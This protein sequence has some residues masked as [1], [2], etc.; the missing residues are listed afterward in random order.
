MVYRGKPSGACERCRSRRLKCDQGIPSCS[1]CIRARVDCPGYR[2]RLDLGFRDQNDEVISRAQRSAQK[3][4]SAA[5]TPV[6]VEES[7]SGTLSFSPRNNVEF[8]VQDL[9]KGY[10]FSHYITGGLEGGHMSYLLPLIADPGNVAVNS[11]LNAVGL[12]ALS[13]I[14]LSPQMMLKAR[15]EYTNALSETN[16]ALANT[17]MSKRDDT[18]AAVVLLGMFEVLTC[19]DGS[20]IDRWMKHMEGATKLIEFRGVDQLSRQEGLNLFTQLR[21]QIH[22]GK[23]YQEKYSSP[24]LFQLSENA[25]RYRDSND[26]IVDELGLEVIRLS[27]FCASMKDGSVTDPG[28]IIRTALTIDANLTSLFISVPAAWSYRTVKVPIFNGEAITRAVWGDTYHI[29]GSLASSSMWNNYRSARILV[30]ELIIDAV[31]TLEASAS[32]DTDRRRQSALDSQS[33]LIAHQLVEDICASVPFNL[34]AGTE[35][36]EGADI[37]GPAPFRVTGAGGFSLMWPLLIAGNSGLACQELRQWIID[38][39]EKI[40]H[41][42]GINQALAMAH[43]LRRGMRSRAWISEDSTSSNYGCIGVT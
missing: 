16:Q 19:S 13:N 9:A 42:M 39:L 18:L 15:R 36:S 33:R 25:M 24:L 26:H 20:F 22:I 6:S 35:V 41:S 21:A 28:E 38:C 10:F 12:A 29:Y 43:L 11:A 34:G 3:K 17:A 37:E 32:E 2:N 8:P 14:R 31:K 23:I 1:A 27:N 5:L 40:G 7:G 4:R 30:H